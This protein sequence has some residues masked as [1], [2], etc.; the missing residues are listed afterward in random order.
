MK[1]GVNLVGMVVRLCS[2]TAGSIIISKWSSLI[3]LYL[4]RGRC[5][6]SI[7]DFKEIMKVKFIRFLGDTE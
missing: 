1:I 4:F 2:V 5:Q 7:K 3:T 6:E